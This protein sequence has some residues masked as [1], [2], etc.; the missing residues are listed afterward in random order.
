M[1]A[2]AWTMPLV[3]AELVRAP[4]TLNLEPDA[5]IRKRIARE[6]KLVD[7]SEFSGQIDIKPWFDGVE[8]SGRWRATYQQICGI[9]L[10]PYETKQDEPVLI[11]CVPPGSET[12][13]DDEALLDPEADDPPDVIEDGVVDV[14][15]YLVEQLAL[16]VDPFPR[17]PGA[18]FE[19]PEE[20]V[21]LS[22]FA[23]LAK[24]APPKT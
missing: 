5:D 14:G 24:L 4:R 11:R 20:T 16:A 8:I 3:L 23:V 12:I 10:D 13:P 17:K 19:P 9:T 7:L 1:M 15:A 2:E 21:I 18:V 22:P 6:L